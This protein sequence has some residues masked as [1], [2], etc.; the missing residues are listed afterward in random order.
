MLVVAEDMQFFEPLNHCLKIS[1]CNVNEL[2]IPDESFGANHFRDRLG[3]RVLGLYL[4]KIE[5]V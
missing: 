3:I 4:R 5:I 2:G 1:T